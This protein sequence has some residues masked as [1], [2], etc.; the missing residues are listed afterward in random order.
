MGVFLAA[1]GVLAFEVLLTR[2]LSV[3]MWYHFASLAVAAAMFGLCA[4]GLLSC[5]A[6]RAQERAA[7]WCAASGL[8]AAA[9]YGV[10]LLF[11]R[12]PLW[13][14]RVLSLLHQNYFEPFGPAQGGPRAAADALLVAVLIALLGVPFA[15]AG[16]VLAQA[17]SEP[18]REGRTYL[19][20]MAGSA[21]GV[22]A[23]LAAMRTGSGPAAFLFLAPLFF[24]AA[25]AFARGAAPSGRAGERR[26]AAAWLACAAGLF[27]AGAAEV[28][29]G[30]AEI[31]FV[32]GRLEPGLLWARWDAGSRVAVFPAAAEEAFRAWGAS[33]AWEGPVPEQ[34]GMVVDDTGYTAL[35][36]VGKEPASLGAFRGNLASAAYRIRK[37][38]EALVIGPGGGKDILCALASGDFR[39]TAVEVNPLV[40]QAADREF[41][42]F[43]GRPYRMPG[44][45]AV[46]AEG[47]HFLAGDRRRYDVIQMTQ[48]FGRLPPSAGAFT[49]T[50]DHLYTVEAF[51]EYLSHL[52]R[53]GILT[54][55]RFLY[56]R[57]VLRIL[58]LA[59]EALRAEGA[60]DPARH[61]AAVRDR[62]LLNILVRRTPWPE[63][64]LRALRDFC[65][66]MGFS[67]YLAPGRPAE[68]L[69]GAVLAGTAPSG[70]GV[71]FDLSAPTDDRP[72]F[73]YTLRPG[74]FLRGVRGKGAEF[75]DRAADVLRGFLLAAFLLCLLVFAGPGAALVRR[76]G[77]APRAA[78]GLYMACAGVAF[79]IWE[80]VAIGRLRLLLGSPVLSFAAGL[81]LVLL[82]SGAGGYL[83]Q[84]ALR[85]RISPAGALAAASAAAAWLFWA[86]PR[87]AS[88]AGLPLALRLA[89]AAGFLLPAGLVMGI[90]FPEGLR[91]FGE[92]RGNAA[93]FYFAV[94][95]GA[96]VLGAAA[97][98]ALAMNA[99]YQAAAM[100]AA[101]LYAACALLLW[102]APRRTPREAA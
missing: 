76:S 78:G 43:T 77:G 35:F 17:F 86:G 41:G 79:M 93:P 7:A 39:V 53:D 84:A 44:V 16:A 75:E 33:A 51:R 89:A 62:G 83:S 90:F 19:G 23:Y 87:L 25:A 42:A 4:G 32:R 29:G 102:T 14:A 34:L 96:S 57:R 27:A 55:T 95:G 26:A 49:M 9:P 40:V 92:G 65:E 94:S 48:V 97:A 81:V 24:L 64:E 15:G 68:G 2:V 63:E 58:S 3:I 30:F 66:R 99:G 36:G 74:A 50:E 47:R 82:F 11:A 13:G 100:A 8:F 5:R 70:E 31:R 67:L 38:G 91:R 54:V 52:N 85:R 59:R 45:T 6:P 22:A 28:R 80:I 88:L 72:F 20:A 56:E 60:A 21:A 12:R 101:G 61:V 1:A 10:L 46:V 73:Y 37:R 69:A 18:G 71:P 98:Q